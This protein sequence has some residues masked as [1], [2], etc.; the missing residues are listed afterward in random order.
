MEGGTIHRS[1]HYGQCS[2]VRFHPN[3]QNI[4]VHF[5]YVVVNKSY[6]IPLFK[7]VFS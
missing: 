4:K 1:G 7:S 5:T 3:V 2:H 6:K